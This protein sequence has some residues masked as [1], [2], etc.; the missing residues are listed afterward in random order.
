MMEEG[1]RGKAEGGTASDENVRGGV[2]DTGNELQIRIEGDELMNSVDAVLDVVSK[3]SLSVVILPS[4]GCMSEGS[5]R[6]H[7]FRGPAACQTLQPCRNTHDSP[8]FCQNPFSPSSEGEQFINLL[9]SKLHQAIE[10]E[11]D[12]KGISMDS[13][14][15]LLHTNTGE[16]DI[17]ETSYYSDFENL[18]TGALMKALE[19]WIE[20]APADESRER[21]IEHYLDDITIFNRIGLHI[22]NKYKEHYQPLVRRELLDE[23]NYKELWIK[24][25]FLRLLRDGYPILLDE[26]QVDVLDIITSVPPQELLE[27]AARQRSEETEEYT[28]E[29][30]A[31]E[32]VDCWLRDRLWILQDYLTE[33]KR[34]E[35]NLLL[36]E[37]GEPENVLS[38]ISTRGGFVSQE[39]PL[40]VEKIKR[41]PPEEVIEYCIQEPFEITRWEE[42]ESEEL[43]EISPQGFAV[44]VTQVILD[45]PIPF[46]QY[47]P[48]LQDA[49]SVYTKVL[50]NGLREKIE[51][52]D[53]I[54]FDWL[55]FWVWGLHRL[56]IFSVNK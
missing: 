34:E 45:D 20:T 36:D 55:P 56:R 21:K 23:E 52:N 33:E 47:I 54:E 53:E 5:T 32:W 39:S 11:A 2:E 30:L 17:R 46:Q 16:V 27:E 28:A 1:E 29:E 44:A 31:D 13:I 22:L 7:R 50:L 42:T 19:L 37:L 35:L 24:E 49:P 40:P 18:L 51:A 41:R 14:A 4:Y 9:K 25:D 6:K 3:E 43:Q 26:D 10:I 12:I 15:G 48:R 38:L 8:G